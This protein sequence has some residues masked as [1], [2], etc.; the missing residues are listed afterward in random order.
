M[1]IKFDIRVIRYTIKCALENLQTHS[2]IV[3]WTSSNRERFSLINLNRQMP[4]LVVLF[5]SI[6]MTHNILFIL[7]YVIPLNYVTTS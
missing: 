3:M 5:V 1:F 6:W 2:H 7:Y 4:G